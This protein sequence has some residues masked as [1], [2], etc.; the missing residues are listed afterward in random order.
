MH[1]CRQGC[2]GMY[3]LFKFKNVYSNREPLGGR[4]IIKNGA[5]SYRHSVTI[6]RLGSCA[7][8][9]NLIRLSKVY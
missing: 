5:E 8:G 7:L 6:V 2:F 4:L 3:E 1:F 9:G